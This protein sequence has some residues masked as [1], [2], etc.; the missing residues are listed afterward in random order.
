MLADDRPQGVGRGGSAAPDHRGGEA[1][2][3]LVG[4]HGRRAGRQGLD[5]EGL[6]VPLRAWKGGEQIAW[7][8]AAA[9]GGDAADDGIDRRLAL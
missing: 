3:V 8:H 7:P 1:G 6:A 9:V 5:D 4:D 2:D